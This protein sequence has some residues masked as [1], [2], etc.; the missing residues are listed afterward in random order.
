M[1]TDLIKDSVDLVSLCGAGPQALR[2]MGRVKAL[3]YLGFRIRFLEEELRETQTAH[4][5]RDGNG[6][7]D[8]VIDLV[9]VALGTLVALGV[10]IDRAWSMV[11]AANMAKVPG[12]NPTRP[13]PTGLPD[14]LKPEGW[15]APD[16]SDNLGLLP[17]IYN[18]GETT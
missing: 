17:F 16:H 8:G 3:D 1:R 2:T 7:V 11:Q 18:D 12:V 14:L 13:N 4:E 5:Q 6:M 9:V 10:D 15:V